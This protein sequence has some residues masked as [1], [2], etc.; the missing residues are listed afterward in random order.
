MAV[1]N[2]ETCAT[3]PNRAMEA[4]QELRLARARQKI[5]VARLLR[6]AT[7]PSKEMLLQAAADAQLAE[8]KAEPI[9]ASQPQADALYGR[10]DD[11]R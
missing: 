3:E 11:T 9:A 10:R 7:P 4:E 2:R 5:G 6:E 1:C 8:V